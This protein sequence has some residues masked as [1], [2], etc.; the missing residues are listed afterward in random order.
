MGV[1]CMVKTDASLSNCTWHRLPPLAC[2]VRNVS[3][4]TQWRPPILVLTPPT[5]TR[6]PSIIFSASLCLV[7]QTY[8]T[9]TARQSYSRQPTNMDLL[10]YACCRVCYKISILVGLVECKVCKAFICFD[11]LPAPPIGSRRCSLC[12]V[13]EI[14]FC[15]STCRT[16]HHKTVGECNSAA[17][18]CSTCHSIFILSPEE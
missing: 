6:R 16:S 14:F 13:R 12:N 15:L 1:G 10:T 18:L 8:S 3:S 17:N 7:L 4:H 5:L 9:V 11:C 2:T